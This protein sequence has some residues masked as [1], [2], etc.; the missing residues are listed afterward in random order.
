MLV[1][2]VA[3]SVKDLGAATINMDK[4]FQCFRN[5]RANKGKNDIS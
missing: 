3:Q 1:G 4:I 2:A 5:G